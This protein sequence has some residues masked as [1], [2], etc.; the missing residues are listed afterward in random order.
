MIVADVA[1][2]D[3]AQFGLAGL[4]IG[5]L[6]FCMW[7]IVTHGIDRVD[8][9]DKRHTETIE[10]IHDSHKTERTEWRESS[11]KNQSEIKAV[12]EELTNVVRGSTAAN[13]S[14]SS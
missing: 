1:A 8:V 9:I 12:V 3:W 13:Q 5:A 10:K 14:R 7:K 6:F 11:D 2:F 4:V